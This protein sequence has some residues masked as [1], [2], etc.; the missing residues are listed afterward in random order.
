MLMVF[1]FRWIRTAFHDMAT[2]NTFSGVGGLDGSI[3]FELTSGE[4]TGFAFNTSLL[5]FEPFFSSHTS[6]SDIIAAGVYAATRSCGGPVISVRG[7]RSDATAAGPIGVPLPQNALPI[8]RQQFSR[9][10]YN[11]TEMIAFTACGHTFGGVH[12]QNFPEIV[13]PSTAPNNVAHMDTTPATFDN[14]I[15]IEFV[16]KTTRDPLVISSTKQ[17]SDLVVFA[18]DSNN[19]TIKSLTNPTTFQNTCKIMFQRMIDTVPSGVTL[20]N[21]IEPYEVKP[22]DL[23]LTLL[24]GGSGIAFTGDVR[25]RTTQRPADSITSVK[26]LYKDRSGVAASTPLTAV[27]QGDAQGFDDTFSFYSFDTR[28]SADTGISSFVVTVT[29]SGKSTTFDNNGAGFNVDDSVLF[30][31]SQSCLDGAGKLTAV[32]AVRNG[33]HTPNLKVVMKTP[34]PSPSVIPSLST[35]SIAMAT[36][37]TVDP[38]SFIRLLIRSLDRPNLAYPVPI[39][40]EL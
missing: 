12:S 5:T 21:V 4:N 16:D 26:L 38:T 17:N 18:S 36:Q 37:S 40:V 25:I 10:G 11:A 39:S 34:R 20:S 7:G 19:A 8:F 2:G 31:K 27:Y 24:E 6:L 23:Q 29:F 35:A 14:R 1:I 15:A 30:Q 32:A 13:P 3:Q 28:L 22:Y 33:A 9:F